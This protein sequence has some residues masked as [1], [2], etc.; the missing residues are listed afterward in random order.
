[1]IA[2]TPQIVE[3][4]NDHWSLHMTVSFC[5]GWLFQSLKSR[6]GAD[7]DGKDFFIACPEDAKE[8]N[9]LPLVGSRLKDSRHVI[10]RMP[11]CVFENASDELFERVAGGDY[12]VRDGQGRGLVFLQGCC[13]GRFYCQKVGEDTIDIAVEAL[14]YG[15]RE[16]R[17]VAAAL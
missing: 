6:Y 9:V 12:V 8:L 10:G 17:E 3:F 11:F 7:D 2:V 13:T 5:E 1:M 15:R 4:A 16:K 14:Q